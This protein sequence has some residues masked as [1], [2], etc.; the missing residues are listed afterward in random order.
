MKINNMYNNGEWNFI[1]IHYHILETIAGIIQNTSIPFCNSNEDKLIWNL[2]NN[3][4][5][6]TKSAYS[7]IDSNWKSTLEQEDHFGWIRKL[8]V[9]SKIKFFTWILHH[10]MLS[11]GQYLHHIGLNINP[12][13]SFCEN[14]V[15]DINHIF[16]EC[17]NAKR[18]WQDMSYACTNQA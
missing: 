18:L 2:T 6:T 17:I 14:V 8:R 3:D 12:N 15:K 11:I 13:Y 7:F 10:N 9:P 1:S 5:F 4:L 16:F